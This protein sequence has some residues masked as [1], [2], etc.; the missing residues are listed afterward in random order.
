MEGTFHAPFAHQLNSDRRVE[1]GAPLHGMQQPLAQGVHG[2]QVEHGPLE[3]GV[4]VGG[5]RDVE[6]VVVALEC[7]L[8]SHW[9]SH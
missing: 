4:H 5:G 9:H 8:H 7:E 6:V 2:Q 1:R 3:G